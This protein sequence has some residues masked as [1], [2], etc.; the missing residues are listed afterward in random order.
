MKTRSSDLI[1]ISGLTV[2]GLTMGWLIRS[3]A[4][5]VN[6]PPSIN[7]SPNS[8][9]KHELRPATTKSKTK[10]QTFAAQ[11]SEISRPDREVF[12]E[13]IA[14][15]DRKVV[16]EALLEQGGPSGFGVHMELMIDQIL[17]AWGGEN[18]EEA[19]AWSQQIQ[20]DGTR[21]FVSGKLIGLMVKTDPSRALAAYLEFEQTNPSFKSEVPGKFFASA[22]LKNAEEFLYYAE[23]FRFSWD[24]SEPCEFAKDFNF[25]Q[26]AD[27]ISKLPK[28]KAG[29]LP[30]GFPHNFYEAWAEHDREAAFK[31]FTGGVLERL[32]D[33]DVFLTGL[34]E[35]D[36]PEAIWSWVAEKIQESDVSN[37]AIRNGFANV[38]SVS[39][40]GIIQ[41]L[42]D[43]ASRDQFLIQLVRDVRNGYPFEKIPSLAISAMSSP[44][45]RLE[46]FSQ[47]Q[48]ERSKNDY[49]QPDIT[50]ATEADLQAWGVTRQQIAD[51]FPAPV[52]KPP[53]SD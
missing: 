19:W 27:G 30:L 48:K 37:K 26:V 13:N 5:V 25:Q 16:I 17:S 47:L 11:F 10:W 3:R 32:G 46:A 7:S 36:K 50:K 2:A 22:A 15:Q 1:W 41:A 38:Q 20:G 49:P 8:A 43:T 51:I 34:E 4:T 21:N 35:H 12:K 40:N 23:S 9:Q 44:H 52:E 14:P 28:K 31:S 45:V 53:E 6:L 39:F 33:F 18:F 24:T 42:P 29:K